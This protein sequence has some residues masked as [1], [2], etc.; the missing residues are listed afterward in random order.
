M[1]VVILGILN[2]MFSDDQPQVL[3][4]NLNNVHLYNVI[5][6]CIS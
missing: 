3:L 6:C 1:P 5:L 2:K 4:Y